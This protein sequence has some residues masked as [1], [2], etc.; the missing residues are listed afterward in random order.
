MMVLN[1]KTLYS[2]LDDLDD[3]LDDDLK[4]TV[5]LLQYQYYYFV[6]VEYHFYFCYCFES[7]SYFYSYSYSRY[8]CCCQYF[9]YYY[10]YLSN[11][12]YQ[13]CNYYLNYFYYHC[14]R[15]SFYLFVCCLFLNFDGRVRF[16]DEGRCHEMSVL[17]INHKNKSEDCLT[18]RSDQIRSGPVVC[19]QRCSFTQKGI[20]NLVWYERSKVWFTTRI[21]LL[22]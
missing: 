7:Y 11:Y 6:V 3:D 8:Y 15:I 21:D 1:K 22:A 16:L 19:M 9:H 13:Q 20:L 4:T 2:Y 14:V 10:Y 12:Y 5:V 17:Y 18:V